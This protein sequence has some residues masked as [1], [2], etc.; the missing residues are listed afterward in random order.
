[1]A[2]NQEEG[3][4]GYHCI[5]HTVI[6]PLL[7]VVCPFEDSSSQRAEAAGKQEVLVSQRENPQM[8]IS[9]KSLR[10]TLWSEGGKFL[11]TVSLGNS[12]RDRMEMENCL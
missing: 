7:K 8:E 5:I 4:G 9:S 3:G 1:M 6:F 12:L 11:E 10:A 2:Q